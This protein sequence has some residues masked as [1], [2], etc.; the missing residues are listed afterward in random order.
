MKT[1]RIKKFINHCNNVK[2]MG[3]SYAEY[4]R[5]GNVCKNYFGTTVYDLK[6]SEPTELIMEA[7]DLYNSA[8]HNNKQ[9]LDTEQHEVGYNR[10]DGKIVSY[11]YKIFRKGKTPLVGSLDRNEMN[12]IH[13]LYSYYGDSLTQRVISR[14]FPELSLIDF[15]R[16][17]NAFSIT[18]ASAPFA[19]HM[20]EEYTEEEL[21]EIQIREKENSF[22]RKAE[23]DQIKNTEK[24][25]KKYAAEN[26]ELKK[27][28]ESPLK[29]NLPKNITPVKLPTPVL[30]NNSL[31]LHLSDLHIGASVTSGTLYKENVNYTKEE[32][33]RRLT[34]VLENIAK[35]SR[36][37]TIVINL[38]GDNVDCCGVNGKTARL[39]HFMP[40][41]MD[42]REQGEAYIELMM[43]FVD[44]I[45]SNKLCNK[46]KVYA[47]PT[48][49]HGGHMEYF[50]NNYIVDCLKLKYPEIEAIQFK[51]FF[52]TYEFNGHTWVICHGKDDLYM[53]KG[54]PLNIDDKSKIMLY[55]WLNDNHVYGDNI[56]IIKGDLHSN[57]MNSCKR[58]T[59]RNVLSLF[60]ASDYS[61]YNFSR[62]SYGVSYELFIGDN[63]VSGT[64]E[65]M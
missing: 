32:V 56:H 43:W 65:N 26:I 61:S 37:D 63:L 64:F 6:K 18:K 16:I 29:I 13:R 57:N 15:K 58:F 48:G 30:S 4:E 8:K 11:Y 55:E 59:Y 10:E 22:L 52:G 40:E 2:K 36:L 21:R 53:K 31:M 17:L 12:E 46:I 20:F 47:V 5:Q 34:I 25:L 19:P 27:Q 33:K 42:A 60:G 54:L 23:S 50:L 44:S 38:L 35:F 3:I 49:N 14:N 1:D 24:L 62:N 41:G 7:L 51:E 39:D 9:Q 28:L 45:V